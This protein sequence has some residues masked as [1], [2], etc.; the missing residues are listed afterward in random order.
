MWYEKNTHIPVD[1]P[2]RGADA[3]LHRRTCLPLLRDK[4][5]RAYW[6]RGPVASLHLR[7]HL[8]HGWRTN[9]AHAVE[10]DR[11]G[12][13]EMQDNRRQRGR[14]REVARDDCRRPGAACRREDA[15]GRDIPWRGERIR[16]GDAPQRRARRRLHAHHGADVPR[17]APRSPGT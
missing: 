4:R 2:C 1:E 16:H 12:L 10:D 9:I 17:G 8:R 11:E 13:D 3:H 7:V 15:R 14:G 5:R 6:R